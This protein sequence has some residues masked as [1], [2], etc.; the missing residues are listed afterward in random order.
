[1]SSEPVDEV[2]LE[3]GPTIDELV[4]VAIE[5]GEATAKPRTIRHWVSK[6]Y[7]SR[8]RQQGRAWRY[9]VAA[10]G[11]VDTIARLRARGVH[12]DFFSFALFIE[13]GTGDTEEARAFVLESWGALIRS[14]CKSARIRYADEFVHPTRWEDGRRLSDGCP[15][16]ALAA[17]RSHHGKHR[18]TTALTV[19]LE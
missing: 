2:A 8:P 13:A 7:V 15:F 11:Q 17:V 18:A 19:A 4:D 14:P 3:L 16:Y 1:V 9:P 12:P 6:G 5:A 10:I